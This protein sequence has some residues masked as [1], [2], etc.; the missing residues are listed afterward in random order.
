MPACVDLGFVLG[1][2]LVT[3]S[4]PFI[5]AIPFCSVFPSVVQ[6]FCCLAFHANGLFLACL[7][8]NTQVTEAWNKIAESFKCTAIEGKMHINELHL[9]YCMGEGGV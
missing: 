3:Q 2:C 8:Q 4:P 6:Y 5:S 9:H 1:E 7:F